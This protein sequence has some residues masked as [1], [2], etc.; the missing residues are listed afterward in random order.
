MKNVSFYLGTAS[1]A[2]P[3]KY[4]EQFEVIVSNPPYIPKQDM[5]TL[6]LEVKFEPRLALDGGDSGLDI[7]EKISKSAYKL[8]QLNG[9]YLCEIGIGQHHQVKKALKH[10]L[11]VPFRFDSIGSQIIYYTGET[12]Y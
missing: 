8:L 3:K 1:K 10:L 12:T 2:I 4:K 7:I 11:H 9:W 5:K 6:Q